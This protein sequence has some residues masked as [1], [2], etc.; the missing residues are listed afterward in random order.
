MNRFHRRSNHGQGIVEFA[1]VLML[2][3]VVVMVIFDLG[4]AVI[5]YSVLN[6]AVREGARY[7]VIDQNAYQVQNVVRGKV[8][9]LEVSPNV[10]FTAEEVTVMIDYP[11]NTVTPV[12][13]LLL[14]GGSILLHSE[15]TMSI[16]Q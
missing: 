3:L 9:G 11:F 4:R 8:N 12:L 2:F 14:P 1:L 16:E 15:S 7:G 13:D 10:S 5:F 6:N